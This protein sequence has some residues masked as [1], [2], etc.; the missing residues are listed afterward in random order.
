MKTQKIVKMSIDISVPL[1]VF[2]EGKKFVA[3]SP[4][5]DLSSCGSSFEKAQDSFIDAAELFLEELVKKNTLEEYLKGLGWEKTKEKW[6]SPT[7]ISQESVPIKI[8]K[9]PLCA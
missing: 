5:L 3:Y 8:R 4:F 1:I 2:K 6:I 7:V 9:I